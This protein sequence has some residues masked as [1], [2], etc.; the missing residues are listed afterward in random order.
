[1]DLSG[2]DEAVRLAAVR[3]PSIE[4]RVKTNYCANSPCPYCGGDDRFVLF[5]NGYWFCNPGEGHCGRSGWL[6]DDKQ[7][8]WTPEE[9]RLRRIE[10]E[11]ARARRERQYLTRQVEALKRMASCTDH[12]RYHRA[13]DEEGFEWCAEQGLQMH[14]VMD[15]QIGRCDRCPTDREGRPSYTF[16][17]WRKDGPLWS[18][19][20]RLV[21]ATNGDKYRPHVSGLGLQ[22]VNARMLPDWSERVIVVEGAKKARVIQGHD[23]PVV[24]ILGKTGF[25]DRWLSWFHPSADVYIALDPDAQEEAD[26]LAHRISKQ[27]KQVFVAQFPAKPDDL[28]VDGCGDDEWEGYLNLA[29]RVH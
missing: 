9:V 21:G 8:V 24:G 7:H 26:K 18:I 5:D 23:F 17:I 28:F 2:I 10:A 19:R 1:M 27:G 20:H 6:D 16:P 14:V 12:Q 11:Q 4:L 25:E 29:R 22:L 13:L 15:Y 3:W